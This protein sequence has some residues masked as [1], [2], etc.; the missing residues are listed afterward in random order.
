MKTLRRLAALFLALTLLSP[1]A[2]VAA[3]AAKSTGS[4]PPGADESFPLER[5]KILL[6]GDRQQTVLLDLVLVVEA[7]QSQV[8]RGKRT[9]MIDAIT[10]AISAVPSS[11]FLGGNEAMRVKKLAR[12]GLDRGGFTQ[13]K[14]V[15]VH[16]LQLR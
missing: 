4:A 2:A 14:D 10:A 16:F 6:K 3:A 12:Q 11:E 5:M 8:L 7:G 9:Q 15:L 13:V 1:V